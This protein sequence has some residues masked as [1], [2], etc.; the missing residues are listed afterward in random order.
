MN[1]PKYY[2]L[3]GK[4][5][6]A[7]SLASWV[8]QIDDRHVGHTILGDNVLT[9]STIFLGLDHNFSGEGDPILFETMIFGD[10]EDAY[11]TRCSTW[12]EAE[13]MHQKAVE[14]ATQMLVKA[15][16][17]INLTEKENGR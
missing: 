1:R 4:T 13:R 16:N 8:M 3:I 11:Q 15:N 6:V 10:L 2:K 7:C 14:L 12:A 9:V 5:P 17:A